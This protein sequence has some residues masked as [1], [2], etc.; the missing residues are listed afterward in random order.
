VLAVGNLARDTLRT[1][2]T[3]VCTLRCSL[4]SNGPCREAMSGAMSRS[5]TA[6]VACSGALPA[7]L[8]ICTAE[9]LK[10][11]SH[12]FPELLTAGRDLPLDTL[13]EGEI[14]IADAEGQSNFGALQERLGKAKRDAARES[15]RSP[16]VL[17]ASTW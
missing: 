8:G 3:V 9:T 2:C 6:S 17:L 15:L 5:S 11:L 7:A 16:A 1:L 13:V 12:A 10:D 14:V 4:D